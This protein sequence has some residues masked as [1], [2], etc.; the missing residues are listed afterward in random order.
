M[1]FSIK[2]TPLNPIHCAAAAVLSLMIA[3]PVSAATSATEAAPVATQSVPALTPQQSLCTVLPV[4][5]APVLLRPC[6]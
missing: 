5:I 2:S 6:C 4:R 1:R 3:L